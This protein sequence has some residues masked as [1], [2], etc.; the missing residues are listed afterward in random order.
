[1]RV[2]GIESSCDD[3]AVCLLEGDQ[4]L[5]S[6]VASQ[7]KL[8]AL[9]GGIV[10]EIASR[11]HIFSISA[12]VERVLAEAPEGKKSFDGVA[13]TAS[14]GLVGS[15][16]VGLNFA[17][18]LALSHGVPFIGV[19]HLE[20]HL[21]SVFLEERKPKFPFLGLAIS[22]G[23]TNLY[24]VEGIGKRKLLGMT[25]DDAAG[26]AYDKVAKILGLG[27]PGGPIL[28]K[29]A[30]LGDPKAVPFALPRV[31]RGKYFTSFSGLKTA[32]MEYVRD[33]GLDELLKK[34]PAAEC[35]SALDLIASFQHTVVSIVERMLIRAADEFEA[36][37]WAVA[38]GVA[39]NS[40]LRERLSKA[41][42]KRGIELFIPR[43]LFCTDNAAMIAYVG[44][45]YLKKGIHS[46]LNLNAVASETLSPEAS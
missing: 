10:P 46:D 2:L 8:H 20:G 11:E 12:L 35:K 26:E 39:C 17:K 19:N 25:V 27:Y 33:H 21:M 38:G 22:G 14:P 23:H 13:V 24:W 44:Q 5:S 29:L 36:A 30:K 43:P 45:E 15:L 37:Q 41:A 1:M 31:K 4:I 7:E 3:L 16:L 28:D 34:K 18:G 32:V 42:Q 40:E 6:R 9:Y